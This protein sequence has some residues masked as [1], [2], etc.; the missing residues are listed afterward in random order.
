MKLNLTLENEHGREQ[1]GGGEGVEIV[2]RAGG[3]YFGTFLF[4]VG[5]N[6]DG[7]DGDKAYLLKHVDNDDVFTWLPIPKGRKLKHHN[8]TA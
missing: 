1:I 7:E 5:Q 3:K 2:L 6:P 8:Q 4:G